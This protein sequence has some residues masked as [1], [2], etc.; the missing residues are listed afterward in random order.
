[1]EVPEGICP[2]GFVPMELRTDQGAEYTSGDMRRIG[3]EIGMNITLV[4]P[5]TGSLK[6]LV[7]QAFHQFQELLRGAAAGKGI[8]LKRYGSQHYETACT[9]IEDVR[10][11]A[12]NFVIYFNQ[13]K[14]NY[15]IKIC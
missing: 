9:D 13:H 12:Y 1:M 4:A 11:I 15:P 6:G 7:E 2:Y 14:R 10:K 8:I 3:R 5:G